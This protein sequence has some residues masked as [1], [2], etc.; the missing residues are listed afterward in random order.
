MLMGSVAPFVKV[1][2]LNWNEFGPA[3]GMAPLC[4][5]ADSERAN[6]KGVKQ[7]N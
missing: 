1:V 5:A 3:T 2:L 4:A 7:L 6:S